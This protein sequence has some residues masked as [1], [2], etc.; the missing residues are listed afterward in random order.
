[1][2]CKKKVVIISLGVGTVVLVLSLVADLIGIGSAGFGG[3]QTAGTV[4]GANVV[5]V[6]LLMTFKK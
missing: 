6:A 3:L 5:V 1:M 2:N 4:V